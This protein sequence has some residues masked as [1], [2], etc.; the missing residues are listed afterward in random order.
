MND[1]TNK[2]QLGEATYQYTHKQDFNTIKENPFTCVENAFQAGAQ[3]LG[4]QMIVKLKFASDMNASTLNR[5]PKNETALFLMQFCEAQIQQ[6]L[7]LMRTD[8]PLFKDDIL[9]EIG[10]VCPIKK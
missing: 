4:K 1:M 5:E 2:E 7:T 6:L 9:K 3:W 8:K 10:Y